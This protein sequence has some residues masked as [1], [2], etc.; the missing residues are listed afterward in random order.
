MKIK[1]IIPIATS[2]ILA[3]ALAVL[4]CSGQVAAPQPTTTAPAATPTQKP[5]A[6]PTTNPTPI[7]IVQEVDKKYN[8]LNPTG[9]FIPVQIKPLAPRLTTVVGKTIYIC[10]GEADPIIMPALYPAMKAKYPT[11]KF[12]YYDVS[13]FGPSSPGTGTTPAAST[14]LPEDVDIFNKAD[15][16]IRGNG[17]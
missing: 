9:F 2:V 14:G 12:L 10:Q 7:T 6:T 17:W 8:V 15:A 3:I 11:T 4:A 16:C 5:A 13:A 1:T